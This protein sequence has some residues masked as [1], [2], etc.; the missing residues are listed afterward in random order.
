MKL[1]SPPVLLLILTHLPH[2]LECI[3]IRVSI[4]ELRL[5]VSFTHHLAAKLPLDKEWVL[6][7]LTDEPSLRFTLLG[8]SC[9]LKHCGNFVSFL[10]SV[11][12]FPLYRFLFKEALILLQDLLLL[13]II[14]SMVSYWK[15][16]IYVINWLKESKN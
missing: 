2:V 12:W 14:T 8:I 1:A 7:I 10:Y 11:Y 4:L 5:S 15:R 9:H 6:S 3:W 16:I 13:H